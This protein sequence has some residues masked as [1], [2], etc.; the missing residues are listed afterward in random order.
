VDVHA[1]L[2][3]RLTGTWRTTTACAG[4]LGLIDMDRRD[5]SEDLLARVGLTRERVPTLF[6]PGETSSASC[7]SRP[8]RTP[9]GGSRR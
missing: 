6:S 1:F 8:G 9:A 7:P 3:N 4:P 2:A 5:W